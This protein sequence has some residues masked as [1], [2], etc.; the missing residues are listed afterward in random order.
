[1]KNL[2]HIGPYRADEQRR[3]ANPRPGDTPLQFGA[4]EREGGAENSFRPGGPR[5]SLKRLNSDKEIQGKPSRFLGNS[6]RRLGP[7]WLNLVRFGSGLAE[8]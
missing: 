5:K 8:L 2:S 7:I 1:M 3:I 6:L 4:S